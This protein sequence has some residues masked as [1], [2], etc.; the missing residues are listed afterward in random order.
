MSR[1]ALHLV[2]GQPSWSF[3]SDRVAAHLTQQGGHLGPVSFELGHEVVQ[4][5]SVAPWATEK[6]D[7]ATIPL[8]RILRGDFFCCPFG[9]NGTPWRGEAHPV[10]GESAASRWTL[11]SIKHEGNSATLQATLATRIRR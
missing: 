2:H 3:R 10:H 4:P 9:G 8:L 7:P 5:F 11:R 1:T 6:V